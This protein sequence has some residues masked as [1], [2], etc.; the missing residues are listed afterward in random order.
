MGIWGM[1]IKDNDTFADI[2]DAFFDLYNKGGQP[3]IISQQIVA[4]YGEILETDEEKHSFWFALALA[5]WETNTLD[6]HV[7]SR[8]EQIISSGEDLIN[9]REAGAS[10]AVIEKR[11]NVL[12]KFLTRLKSNKPSVKSRKRAKQKVSIFSSGDC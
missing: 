7:L 3:E 2:Y 8:V 12:D 10:E 9:W 1:A 6:P 11:M 5:Q 4:E